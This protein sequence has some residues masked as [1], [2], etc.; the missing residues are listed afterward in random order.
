M[1]RFGTRRTWAGALQMSLG[2]KGTNLRRFIA[3]EQSTREKNGAEN[4][5]Y[6]NKGIA[7]SCDHDDEH[8]RAQGHKNCEFGRAGHGP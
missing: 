1:A 3:T 6:D 5:R 8:D 4:N 7:L 2:V